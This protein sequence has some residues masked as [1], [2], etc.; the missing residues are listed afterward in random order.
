MRENYRFCRQ[1]SDDFDRTF[2]RW[3]VEL[4]DGI[5]PLSFAGITL[6][7]SLGPTGAIVAGARVSEGPIVSNNGHVFAM[8]DVIAREQDPTLYDWLKDDGRFSIFVAGLE[9]CGLNF[10]LD[11]DD[12]SSLLTVLAPTDDAF[13]QYDLMT[14]NSRFDVFSDPVCSVNLCVTYCRERFLV[15][16]IDAA[17]ESASG[18]LL[19]VSGSVT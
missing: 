19:P 4:T 18:R 12:W 11:Q 14:N 16:E 13:M 5:N 3:L 8:A 17:T 15:V 7:I 10:L 2:G 6:P 1:S 9:G